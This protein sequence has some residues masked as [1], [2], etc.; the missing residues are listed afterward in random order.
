MAARR[1]AEAIRSEVPPVADVEPP[2]PVIEETVQTRDAE[3][4]PIVLAS[5][6][7]RRAEKCPAEFEAG[8][9]EDPA[10][11][12]PRLEESD[13]VIPFVVQPKIKN[14]S[15]SSDALAMK[16]PAVAL[17]MASSISL[18]FDKATFHSEPDLLTI[19]R[20][21]EISRRQHDFIERIGRLQSEVDGQRSRAEF[22]VA[23][24]KMEAVRAEAEMERARNANQ[25]RLA[26]EQKANVSEAAL[27]LAQEAIAKLEAD[28]AESKKAKE[29]ADSEASKAY[30]AGQGAAL[31]N[32]V[33]ELF[34]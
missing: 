3:S 33:E 23:R 19:G 5:Q 31:A 27:K 25:L 12:Q 4:E 1:R 11:K 8:S 28:L 14:M 17:S 13:T 32:Y 24:A 30:E 22:E 7:E 21:A 6:E 29:V 26:A 16:D 2:L 15:I 20:I 34:V 9:G 10:D 18:S